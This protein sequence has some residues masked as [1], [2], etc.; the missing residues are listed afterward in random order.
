MYLSSVSVM[1]GLC[2]ESLKPQSIAF[3]LPAAAA[4]ILTQPQRPWKTNTNMK[5]AFL[6]FA[7]FSILGL[8]AC[9]G[10]DSVDPID[11]YIGAWEGCISNAPGSYRETLG[12]TK[13]NATTAKSTVVLV[14]YPNPGCTGAA[15]EPVYKLINFNL[16]GTKTIGAETVDKVIITDF[17][18]TDASFTPLSNFPSTRKDVFLI[19]NSTFRFSPGGGGPLDAEGYPNTLSADFETRK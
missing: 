6:I 17:G 16:Q 13:E 19:A 5:K 4:S 14:N 15:G 8:T 10:G 11:K 3:T 18:V 2:I 1:L 7:S 12:I 9:G